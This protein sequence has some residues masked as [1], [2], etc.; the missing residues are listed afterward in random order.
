MNLRNLVKDQAAA[1]AAP[2]KRADDYT[3]AELKPYTGRPG[4]MDA[5]LL[6]SVINGVRIPRALPLCTPT[7]NRV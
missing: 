5:Y 7:T 4:A 1:S 6:P 3:G 2:L